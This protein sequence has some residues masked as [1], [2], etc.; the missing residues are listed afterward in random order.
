MADNLPLEI[1]LDNLLSVAEDAIKTLR[2]LGPDQDADR[3][4]QV[5]SAFRATVSDPFN[6]QAV[7][8]TR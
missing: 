1:F 8:S 4:I 7:L 5:R 2:G 3:R 6:Q